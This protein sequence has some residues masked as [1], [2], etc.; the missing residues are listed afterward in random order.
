VA[1]CSTHCIK[2]ASLRDHHKDIFPTWSPAATLHPGKARG[3]Q[4][5]YFRT[6]DPI[7]SDFL[8]PDELLRALQ[9]LGFT[10]PTPVQQQVIPPAVE[11]K[12]LLV[13][14]ATGSGKTAAFLL[15]MMQ[16]FLDCPSPRT[17]TRG[18]I[19]VPTRELGRQILDHFLQLGSYT[20]LG[21][22]VITGGEPMGRQIATLRKNPDILIATPGRLLEHLKRGSAELDDLEVLVLDEADRM[23]DMG[24]AFDVLTILGYCDRNRQSLLFSATLNHRGLEPITE[25]LL[26]DPIVVISNPKRERHP[27]IHHQ[28]LLADDPDHKQAL[29]LWLLSHEDFDKAL[30][31]T[32]TRER[33]SALAGLLQ[34]QGQRAGAIHGELDQRERNR[35][36]GLL[37]NGQIRVLVGTDLAAR[38][39]DV[40]GIDLVIN[41][42]M[43]RSGDDYLHRTGRTGRAGESGLAISL[44]G[45]HEWNRMQSIERY[46]R[47][48]FEPRSI[49][50]LAASFQGPRKKK[51]SGKSTTAKGRKEQPGDKTRPIKA[52]D[53]HRD[54]KNIGKRRKPSTV[55]AVETGFA[56][57]KKKR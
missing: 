6:M 17:G 5:L 52:K 23:L 44:V 9:K 42:D 38:G 46:L 4:I 10:R 30:V 13:S 11:R 8:L 29:L 1:G 53:R 56:P 43:P 41:V 21:A 31:F 40:P 49:E 54:R 45:T 7:F 24:F 18:L 16:R 39:L 32:N 34:A 27:D 55:T 47:L 57:P 48:S 20:R 12:D 51:S 15:P 2:A 26:R 36:M 35:V 3:G 19:L 33:A 50:D 22:E 14:A 28:V 37:R 25:R